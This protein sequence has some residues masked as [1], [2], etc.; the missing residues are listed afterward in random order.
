[1]DTQNLNTTAVQTEEVEAAVDKLR[2]AIFASGSGSNFEALAVACQSGEIDGDVAVMVC[3]KP[4]AKVIERAERLGIKTLVL[5]PKNFASKREYELAILEVLEAEHVEL[6]C[7]AG[8][9]RIITDV[10]LEAYPERIVNVHPSLLPAFKGAHA[11]EQALEYG[12]KFF[13]VSIH[14]VTSELDGGSIIDQEAF[15]Y[16]G[17]SV[18]ELE[19]MVHK[20][21]HPLYIRSVKN[22]VEILNK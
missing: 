11:I 9:M 19:E 10:L 17:R 15:R 20:V 6:I 5:S 22:L 21:E 8:Y 4:G 2:L 3:D 12:V 16:E 7:L 1:M 13:G 14:Y 18:E